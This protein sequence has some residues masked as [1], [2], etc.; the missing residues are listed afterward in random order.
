MGWVGDCKKN[1]ITFLFKLELSL[2]HT[3][4]YTKLYKKNIYNK[5]LY[6][7]END[8]KMMMLNECV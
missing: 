2:S 8:N 5:N 3:T 7:Q 6:A 4:N 1:K